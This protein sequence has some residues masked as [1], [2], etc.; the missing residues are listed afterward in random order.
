MTTSEEKFRKRLRKAVLP[1]LSGRTWPYLCWFNTPIAVLFNCPPSL[2]VT[3][4]FGRGKLR[5]YLAEGGVKGKK[6][7]KYGLK[8]VPK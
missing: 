8:M 1:N 3:T 5:N 7:L 6:I 4:R 2:L